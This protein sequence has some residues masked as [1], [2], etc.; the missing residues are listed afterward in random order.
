[1]D[2]QGIDRP[3]LSIDMR[4]NSFSDVPTFLASMEKNLEPWCNLMKKLS[5]TILNYAVVKFPFA[6]FD[7]AKLYSAKMTPKEKLETLFTTLQLL[8][9]TKV[10]H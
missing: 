3:I 5:K 6:D 4:E 7:L 10:S 8:E 1:M 2:K 9:W